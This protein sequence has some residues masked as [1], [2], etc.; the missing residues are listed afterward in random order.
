MIKL[1][2]ILFSGW[3]IA[4]FS[5]DSRGF[6]LPTYKARWLGPRARTCFPQPGPR[7]TTA[8]DICL[9]L[10]N[11]R[12]WGQSPGVSARWGRGNKERSVLTLPP[13]LGPTK[14]WLQ[15][16][17]Q[18]GVFFGLEQLQRSQ[19]DLGKPGGA[20]GFVEPPGPHALRTHLQ[21]S[22]GSGVPSLR[23]SRSRAQ[24][25]CG[26]LAASCALP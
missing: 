3:E 1:G 24:P 21:V 25:G 8:W 5:R 13:S 20:P 14:S 23:P 15:G 17:R 2:R 4:S 9:P 26:E 11:E 6:A 18:P 19:E 22:C 12:P 10:L 16:T 7:G